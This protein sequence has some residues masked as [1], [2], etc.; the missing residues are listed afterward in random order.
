MSLLNF[1]S[2]YK[3]II[4]CSF[5]TLQLLENKMSTT[6]CLHSKIHTEHIYVTKTVA[7]WAITNCKLVIFHSTKIAKYILGP[8]CQLLIETV[9]WFILS[10]YKFKLQFNWL[11]PRRKRIKFQVNYFWRFSTFFVLMD[12]ILKVKDIYRIIVKSTIDFYPCSSVLERA[13]IIAHG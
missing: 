8:R 11:V 9:S 4:C 6:A 7:L 12:V 2:S 10:N 13:K 5:K 3:N 1:Y